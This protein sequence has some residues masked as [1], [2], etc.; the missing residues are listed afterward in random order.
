MSN[1]KPKIRFPTI[2]SPITLSVH[3]IIRMKQRAGLKTKEKRKLFVKRAADKGLLFSQIPNIDE[4][5]SF[6]SYY[7]RIIKSTKRKDKG[8]TVYFYQDFFILISIYGVILTVIKIDSQFKSIFQ[9]IKNEIN[10]IEES[11][12]NDS[13]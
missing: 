4:F 10:R 8:V 3:S 12:D 7:R 5:K 9:R 1:K 2:R 6:L 13:K 11:K